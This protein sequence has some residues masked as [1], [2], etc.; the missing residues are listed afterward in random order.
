MLINARAEY[1][2]EVNKCMEARL[3]LVNGETTF[4]DNACVVFNETYSN[5]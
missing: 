2:C 4:R 1:D 5:N 3:D